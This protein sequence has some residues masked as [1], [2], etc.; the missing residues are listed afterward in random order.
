[1]R[2]K[3]LIRGSELMSAG[4]SATVPNQAD[5]ECRVPVLPLPSVTR[6]GHLPSASPPP[7]GVARLTPARVCQLTWPPELPDSGISHQLSSSSPNSGKSHRF[8]GSS[9]PGTQI[10]A[11]FP[12]FSTRLNTRPCDFPL[13]GDFT[14]LRGQAAL[15]V[16]GGG[17][18]SGVRGSNEALNALALTLNTELATGTAGPP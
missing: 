11:H 10:P 14:G 3:N 16:P 6:A 18:K 8:P 15:Q 12:R 17:G 5:I 1:M 13:R 2:H 4:R 9:P 7:A